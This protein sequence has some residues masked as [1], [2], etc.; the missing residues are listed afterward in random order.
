MALIAT[1]GELYGHHQKFRDLFL[2]RLV[3]PGPDVRTAASTSPPSARSW[4]D[5]PPAPSPT[6]IAERTSWSCHHGVLR[7]TAECPDAPTDAGRGRCARPS[8]GSLRRSTW[9]PRA[10]RRLHG[11]R[12]VVAG[13]RRVRGRD[14]RR[15]DSRRVRA[16]LAARS[17]RPSSARASWFCSR[18]SAGGWRCSPATA[19]SGTTRFGRRPSTSCCARPRRPPDRRRRRHGPRKRLVDDLSLL[20]SPSRR[21]D[22]A[23]IYA[24][25]LTDAGQ[26][27]TL[28]PAPGPREA[29]GRR[30]IRGRGRVV[31]L[32]GRG[33]RAHRAC[34]SG[35]PDRL[36]RIDREQVCER[37]LSSQVRRTRG[38]RVP[39][40]E[41]G[42]RPLRVRPSAL[43]DE[44]Q[45]HHPDFPA[46]RAFAK[47]MNDRA[48]T[49]PAT[50][51]RVVHAAELNAMGLIDEISHH[52]VEIYRRT[53]NPNVM[54]DAM[55]ALVAELG[56][57]PAR[58]GWPA[59]SSSSRRSP[60]IA[61]ARIR[62][63]TSPARP[64]ATPTARS[65]SKSC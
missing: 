48:D 57:G 60:S 52:A 46:A 16:A 19:G 24:E 6:Q 14:L 13:T 28:G 51:D 50:P 42:P 15:G 25:A 53:V 54:A 4:A 41:G 32:V 35:P 7:W 17:P 37:R 64:R 20:T 31:D 9:W 61:T 34:H 27:V 21:I 36:A 12:G 39:R 1:D 11:T 3:N 59:S 63:N 22:G 10:S 30:G 2:A 23:A 62:P 44:R 8:S 65:P 55:A 43:P 45:R 58:S 33:E 56:A 26:P 47:R 38:I 18:R 49:E 40:L 29:R 5:T